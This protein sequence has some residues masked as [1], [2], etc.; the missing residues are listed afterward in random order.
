VPIGRPIAGTTVA[1][2]DSHLQPVPP[3]TAGR[4][5]HRRC[6]VTRGYHDRPELTAERFTEVAGLGR[7]YRT[8]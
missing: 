6:G 1:V 7:A 4:A 2:V 5:R 8:G 3:G